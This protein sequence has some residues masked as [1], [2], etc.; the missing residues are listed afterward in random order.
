MPRNVSS[1]RREHVEAYLDYLL[2]ERVDERN[3]R[4]L[5][6]ATAKNRYAS[7]RAFFAW[8][9]REGEVKRSPMATMQPP[10]VD[11]TL[12]P[13]LTEDNRHPHS[14]RGAAVRRSG[15]FRRRRRLRARRRGGQTDRAP[16]GGRVLQGQ[17]S[18]RRAPNRCRR[19]RRPHRGLRRPLEPRLESGR[20]GP[21]DPITAPLERPRRA[22]ALRRE[23][24]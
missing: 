10:K 24:S 6:P 11:E 3:G 2:N 5:R 23:R 7:L 18:Q 8:A 14:R 16:R 1:I 19:L 22:R 21:S 17:R 9:V 20:L 12:T 4:R 13:V 15:P